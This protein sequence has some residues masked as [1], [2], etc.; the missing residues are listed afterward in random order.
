VFKHQTLFH[1]KLG[2]QLEQRGGMTFSA[3]AAPHA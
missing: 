3:A 2:A 1:A